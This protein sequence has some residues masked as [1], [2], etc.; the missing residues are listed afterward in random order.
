M[1]HGIMD[2]FI[3]AD[4]NSRIGIGHIMRCIALAQA[5]QDHEGEI[6]FISHCESKPLKQ[7]IQEEGFSF[8]S[9][10][11]IHPNPTDLKMTLSIL[12]EGM[13]KYKKWLVLDGYH[14]TPEYQKA[15]R[16]RGIR[17]LVIDDMDHL[18]YYHADILINHN[19]Y[20]QELTYNCNG[21]TNLLLGARYVFLRKE[22]LEYS[23]LRRNIPDRAR[24]ILVTLGGADPDNVALKVIEALCLFSNLQIEVNIVV[25]PANINQEKLRDALDSSNFIYHLLFNPLNIPDLM[26]W[27]DLAISAGGNTIWEL[28]F[29][30]VPCV[31]ITLAENQQPVAEE[32][33]KIGMASNLGWHNIL[34]QA[35]VM[36]AV[37]RLIF[38]KTTRREMSQKGQAIINGSGVSLTIDRIKS[39]G[40]K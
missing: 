24:N 18:P 38:S 3:R 5:W 11:S 14:F 32:L 31:I 13:P 6:T 21:D 34:S 33:A 8:I 15:I 35:D 39:Y 30:G 2:L 4:A 12:K 7:R 17:L 27:A 10:N 1:D 23:N 29:M 20:A 37:K 16:D 22:F 40:K 28:A 25:G 19:I 36:Q 26:A 9:L